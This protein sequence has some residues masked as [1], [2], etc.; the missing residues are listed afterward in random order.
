MQLNGSG[1]E[2]GTADGGHSLLS[3]PDGQVSL[4]I[5]L[6][7]RLSESHLG[8]VFLRVKPF[9]I[10]A[11]RWS[12]MQPSSCGT[13]PFLTGQR[14]VKKEGLKYALLKLQHDQELLVHNLLIFPF[15]PFCLLDSSSANCFF[16]FSALAACSLLVLLSC[17]HEVRMSLAAE[18]TMYT[19]ICLCII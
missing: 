10:S 9:L 6:E 15:S 8:L 19:A 7:G 2:L 18:H 3:L 17:N 11:R 4:R 12:M 5:S 13:K 16:L 14:E 1:A